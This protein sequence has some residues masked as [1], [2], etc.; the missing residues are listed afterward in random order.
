MSR[1][2]RRHVSE[3]E[4]DAAMLAML[5]AAC[6]GVWRLALDVARLVARLLP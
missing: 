1:R 3:R 2:R 5:L 4:A 6:Y